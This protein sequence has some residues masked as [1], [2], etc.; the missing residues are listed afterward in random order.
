MTAAV[1]VVL[2][3]AYQVYVGRY[4]KAQLWQKYT[5]QSDEH[6]QLL[7]WM[8][9]L[10]YISTPAAM[11]RAKFFVTAQDELGLLA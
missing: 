3:G 1:A 6:G 11:R 5:G 8:R 10:G 2:A 9:K 4:T 7:N